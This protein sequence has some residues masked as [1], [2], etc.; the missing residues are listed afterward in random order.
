MPWVAGVA[1]KSKNKQT[2]NP[3][4]TPDSSKDST[5]RIQGSVKFKGEQLHC[6]HFSK[7]Q[8][9]SAIVGTGDTR[10]RGSSACA[11]VT[12]RK[13]MFPVTSQ[14]L[15]TFHSIIDTHH[16]FKIVG[17]KRGAARSC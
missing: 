12:S 5:D 8:P 13:Q 16:R 7:M 14:W 10:G 4:N 1:L 15:Q 11:L 9:F 17:A 2:I 6:T 3:P